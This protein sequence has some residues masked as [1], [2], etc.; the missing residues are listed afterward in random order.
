MKG[1]SVIKIKVTETIHNVYNISQE[2][3]EEAIKATANP[4]DLYV[5]ATNAIKD[6]SPAPSLTIVSNRVINTV[7]LEF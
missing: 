7:E 2:Q 6:L 3:W 4:M 5:V 1:G